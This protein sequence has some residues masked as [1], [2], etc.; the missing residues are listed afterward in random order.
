MSLGKDPGPDDLDIGRAIERHNLKV[1]QH[2]KAAIKELSPE[3]FEYLVVSLLEALGYD[4]RHTGRGGDG[5]V[6]AVAVLSL[7]GRTS[8]VTRSRRSVGLTRSPAR[9]CENCGER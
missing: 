8:V 7:G 1:R 6:D 9:R 4:V 5:G 2:L 3:A